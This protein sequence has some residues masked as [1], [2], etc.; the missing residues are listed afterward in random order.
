MRKQLA[1]FIFTL[2]LTQGLKYPLFSSTKELEIQ[3][4]SEVELNYLNQLPSNDYIV[5]PGD[6]LTIIVSRDYP[7]LASVEIVVDG[8]GT[9]YLPKLFRVYVKDLTI[10]EL[11]KLLTEAY[12]KYTKYPEVET[13]VSRYR[14]IQ[15]LV[16]GEVSNP[17]LYTLEGSLSIGNKEKGEEGS[18]ITI[19]NYFP[20]VFDGIKESGGITHLSDLSNVEVIRINSKSNGGGKIK[21]SLDFE[22]LLKGDKSQN[23]RIYDGDVIRIKRNKETNVL[24]SKQAIYTNLNPKYIEVF[25]TGRVN[26][27]GK[28]NLSRASVLTDAVI[29]AGGKKVISGPITFVRYEN[30]GTIDKRKFAFRNSAKRGSYKNPLLKDGDLIFVGESNFSKTTQVLNEVTSPFQGVFSTYSLIKAFRD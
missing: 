17:G 22:S 3:N 1:L 4:K 19:Q 21:T 11:N 23:I 12:K 13:L 18:S 25:V 29:V 7:E 26:D 9:V 16:E 20:T 27:P 10:S 14:P 15:I 28:I 30:D 8:E 24:V 6:V 2:F 5:G